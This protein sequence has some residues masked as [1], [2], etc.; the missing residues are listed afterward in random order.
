[1]G[2]VDNLEAPRL[3]LILFRSLAIVEN[4]PVH[5]IIYVIRLQEV[6]Q[7]DW[8][9]K[10]LLKWEEGDTPELLDRGKIL[11]KFS[12]EAGVAG[13]VRDKHD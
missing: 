2:I 3:F 7:R 6:D 8:C 11:E 12:P 9:W 10:S 4:S 5:Y 1:M 13:L